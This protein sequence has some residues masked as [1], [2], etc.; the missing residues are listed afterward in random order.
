[1]KPTEITEPWMDLEQVL[2]E[3]GY[4]ADTFIALDM[5]YEDLGGEMPKGA[6]TMPVTMLREK[7]KLAHAA[8]AV[9]KLR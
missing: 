3:L 1:M 4:L 7:V 9:M 5:L 2:H 6:L 8:F